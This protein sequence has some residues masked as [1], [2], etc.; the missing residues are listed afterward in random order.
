MYTTLISV[1]QLDTLLQAEPAA[2]VVLDCRF[3]LTAPEKGEAVYLEGHITGAGYLNLDTELSSPVT[4][5]SGRHPLPDFATLC[6]VLR[7]R[8]VNSGTQVV[9]YDDCNGAMASRA[10]WL[11]R[12]LGHKQVA[13]LDGGY[14]AWLAAGL[15]VSDQLPLPSAGD[16]SGQPDLS[17]ILPLQQVARYPEEGALVD[18]RTPERFRGEQEPIDPVAGHIPGAINRPLQLNLTSDG[19]F[20]S[21]DQLHQ[22]WLS[23]LQGCPSQQVVHYCGSGVTACHN[24]LAMEHAGLHGSKVYPGSWSEWIRDPQRPVATG[25]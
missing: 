21:A 18:A 11:L 4:P 17:M 24:Q 7:K 12:V 6:A 16:F 15:P 5:A 3:Y 8:G 10:W 25:Q 22:E 9:V 14:P 23:F 19:L 2:V 13:V 20:K 1:T